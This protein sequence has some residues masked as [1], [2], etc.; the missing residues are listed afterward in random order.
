MQRVFTLRLW[1]LA[2]LGFAFAANS[3]MAQAD[4]KARETALRFL[5]ENPARFGL[6]AADVADVRVTDEYF[7]KNNG[8]TH[9]WVQQQ[10]QGIPVYNGLFGLHV[11]PDGGVAHLAHRFVPGLAGKVNTTLPSLSAAQALR[12]ALYNIGLSDKAVPSLK[13]TINSHNLVFAAGEVAKRDI[14]VSICLQLRPDG[15]VR[16]AWRVEIAQ[17]NTADH[18]NMR[19]DAQTGEI[20]EK[21]NYTVYCRAGHVHHGGTAEACTDEASAPAPAL[22]A[23]Q[24]PVV[25]DETYNVFALPV[26]SPAHGPRSLVVNPANPV[27][28]PYGWLDVNG[29]AGAEYNYTR[30]N[31]VWAYDD[32]SNDGVGS[33]AE[34]ASGGA[35]LVFDHPYDAQLEPEGNLD[36]A[37]TNLFYMNNMMHDITYLYGFDEKAGNFQLNNYGNGGQGGD[38]V[39]AQAIDGSGTNNANFS[40]PPDGFSGTMQMYKWATGSNGKIL[41]VNSPGSIVGLYD[42]TAANFGATIT[43]VPVTGVVVLANDGTGEPTLGC[44]PPVNDI[45]GKVALI[46]RGTCTFLEKVTIAQAA[47]AIAV[48]VANF[49]ESTVTM[50]VPNGQSGAGINIPS[51]MVPKSVGDLLKANLGQG[52]EVSLVQPAQAAGPDFLDADFDNGIIAHEYGHGISNR[53]TGGPSNTGCLGNGEQMGEGWSDYFSLI[54]SAKPGD[55]PGQKRGVGT[56]VLSEPNTGVGIRRYPYSTDMSINPVTFATVALNTQVHARGEIWAAVTWDLYWAMVEKYGYDPDYT[57]VNSGNGRAIQLVM[58]GMKLQPCSPGFIDGRDAIM[59]ADIL[60]YN[61]EDTCLI[62]FVFARRG[63]GIGADQG[64]SDNAA[65]GVENFDPI[66]TCIKEL[67]ISKTTADPTIDPGQDVHFTIT[68]TNH[69][70]DPATDV[71]VTDELPA[72]LTFVSAS[73]GGTFSNGQVVWNLGNMAH[74]QVVTLNYVAKCDPAFGS[75]RFYRDELESAT[76]LDY[77]QLFFEGQQIFYLQNDIVKTGDAAYRADDAPSVTDMAMEYQGQVAVTGNQPVLRFWHQI[78]SQAGVDG[79]FIEVRRIDE[80]AWQRFPLAASFRNPPKGL[81]YGTFAIPFLSAYSGNSGGWVQSYF[82]LS[83]FN[84]ETIT[85]RFRFGTNETVSVGGGWIVDDVEMMDMVNFDGQ[86]CVTS[87]QNDLA[88]D[89]VPERGVIVNPLVGGGVDASEP[90]RNS[91]DLFV[92]PNPASEVLYVSAGQDLIGAVQIELFAADGRSV[93]QQNLSNGLGAGQVVTMD[94]QQV[95]A[96]VYVLRLNGAAGSSVKTVVVK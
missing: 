67:K 46:D 79:G 55:M 12:M 62:S 65:D 83:Q 69:K 49:E 94:L 26:E 8:V 29:E 50:G 88:C 59:L 11:K 2:A 64:S 54:T 34:S 31:N 91:F 45:S 56:F 41:K 6:S 53:L 14:P 35:N 73:N 96:G 17:I 92:Q 22:K 47:G 61:G 10:H 77:L 27:A 74:N 85:Y 71:V 80:Q 60:N 42:A 13:N 40:T 25:A 78:N 89:R 57:N 36:A 58:D 82:D 23:Q 18:W 68:V 37:V 51:V 28:S 15:T 24:P 95:P 4:S 90:A 32:S 52:V 43:T 30:G 33:E 66:P 39:E 87:A 63:M 84:G 75:L 48:I 16:L 72:G 21:D 76:E 9:V 93:L 38:Y 20:L 3:L 70:D 81:D 86:A 19:V 44:N 5:R 7:S 1:L